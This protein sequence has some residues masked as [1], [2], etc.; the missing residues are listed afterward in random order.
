LMLAVTKFGPAMESALA[1]SA[2]NLICAYIYELAG[3]ANKFYHETP[4]LKEED[5]QKKAGYIALM[6]LTK[7]ILEQCIALLGFQAPEKM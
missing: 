3:A 7:Q 2:P 4:I 5:E 1:N 6:G